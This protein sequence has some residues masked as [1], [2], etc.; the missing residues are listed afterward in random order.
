MPLGPSLFYSSDRRG[1][2]HPDGVSGPARSIE[3]ARVTRCA[4]TAG[5]RGTGGSLLV[6]VRRRHALVAKHVGVDEGTGVAATAQVVS[7]HRSCV[8]GSS[9]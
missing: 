2:C 3:L 1:P 4:R 9:K 6:D 7:T 8:Q 5:E